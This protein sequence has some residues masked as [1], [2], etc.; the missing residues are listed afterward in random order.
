M[1]RSCSL[2]YA[3][4]SPIGCTVSTTISPSRFRGCKLQCSAAQQDVQ[5][6]LE[7]PGTIEDVRPGSQEGY[8]DNYELRC[9]DG[10]FRPSASGAVQDGGIRKVAEISNL[11]QLNDIVGSIT[12]GESGS[13]DTPVEPAFDE[14][15]DAEIPLDDEPF[16]PITKISVPRQKYIPVPKVSLVRALVNSFDNEKRKSEFLMICSLLDFILHAEHKTI[17]E[18]MRLDYRITRSALKKRRESSKKISYEQNK[19]RNNE[20]MLKKLWHFLRRRKESSNSTSN[21][22]AD[23][24]Q[25]QANDL[26]VPSDLGSPSLNKENLGQGMHSSLVNNGGAFTRDS[27]V[28]SRSNISA[29]L[30]D[31]VRNSAMAAARFQRT[32]LKLLKNAQFQGLSTRDLQLTSA[33]NTDY[34]L[35][36]PIEVDWK[37]TSSAVA[38]IF[39]RGYASERQEGLLFGAKLD[40]L[41]SLLL[42]KIFNWFSKPLF[43]GGR[44]I[45]QQLKRSKRSNGSKSWTEEFAEWLKEPLKPQTDDDAPDL[46]AESLTDEEKVN[47]FPIWIAAQQA[48]PRYEAFLSSVGSRGMLLRKILMWMRILPASAAKLPLDS[49]MDA[50]SLDSP[51]RG[52]NI[53]RISMRDIW[54]PASK[55]V[56]GNN[57]WKQLRAAISVFFSR[58]TLQEPAYKELVLLYNVP[59]TDND[60]KEYKIPELQLKIYGKIPIPDLKVIFPN[61]KLSF[62]ILDTV[63]L[64]IATIIG[65]LAFLINYRFDNFLSSPSAFVLDIIASLALVV[66][67]TRVTL[68]YKQTYDRYQLLVNKTLYEK[69]LASGFGAAHFLVDAS[70]QQQFKECALALALLLNKRNNKLE[71]ST[72]L[73]SRCED[74]LFDHFKEQV[75]MPIDDALAILSRLELIEQKPTAA[76]NTPDSQA[77]EARP[78][79]ESMAALRERW[80]DVVADDS[81]LAN[82]LCSLYQTSVH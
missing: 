3:P 60:D 43:R 53:A 29:S 47:Y 66:Y 24:F 4:A 65:L 67:I 52:S 22:L 32:F 56:C 27:G 28:S 19:S 44:W 31:T 16:E 46:L 6:R 11:D 5:L 34:L 14:E 71:T 55:M 50:R 36:L 77:L 75:E 79:A 10:A 51:L 38:I 58:S 9:S 37:Y 13:D 35:T 69:T 40:Y 26:I 82:F 48:V 64:D 57:L 30:D 8:F 59:S 2:T 1:I 73:A 61:K 70:E 15:N 18:Q 41:Q 76:T 54:A 21:Q 23:S 39:R 49:I 68:G 42:R 62:R 33:L 12:D 45:N 7:Q 20:N 63:R 78:H 17:L 72:S 80:A 74:F 81:L 25:S